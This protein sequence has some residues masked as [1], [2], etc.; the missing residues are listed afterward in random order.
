MSDSSK[1]EFKIIREACEGEIEAKKSRFIASVFPCRTE[2]E[3]RAFIEAVKKRHYDARHNCFAMRFIENSKVLERFSDDGEPQGTAGKPML[4]ILKGN[5]LCDLCAVVTRYFG[6]T[7]LGTGGLVRAYSDALKEALSSAESKGLIIPLN[8]GKIIS[9][10][11]DYSFIN[12]V[13]YQAERSGLFPCGEEYTEKCK[14]SY[15]VPEADSSAFVKTMTD[16][17]AGKA[18]VNTESSVLFGLDSKNKIVLY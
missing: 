2:D 9:V 10:S 15:V 11:S 17:S 4:D 13:K 8:K 5:D 16:M 7:L 14:L 1:Y 12:R 3:A 6:G 18:E